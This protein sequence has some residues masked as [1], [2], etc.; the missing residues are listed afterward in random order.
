MDKKDKNLEINSYEE[1]YKSFNNL[2]K[3]DKANLILYLQNYIYSKVINQKDN[4]FNIGTDELYLNIDEKKD[5][6][7]DA[8]TFIIDE[9][10][11]ACKYIKN[12][13]N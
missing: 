8:I 11:E 12:N 7:M 10:L 5:N 4:D 1:F 2:Q 9:T 6:T 13:M 3:Q